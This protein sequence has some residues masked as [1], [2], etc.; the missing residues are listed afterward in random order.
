MDEETIGTNAGKVWKILQSENNVTRYQLVNAT[1]LEPSDI[2][3]AIG[4][5]AK[6]NK[7]QR[8]GEFFSL[9]K[10]NMD[11]TIGLNAQILFKVLKN[12]PYDVSTLHELTDLTPIE[13]HQAIGWLS[14]EGNVNLTSEPIVHEIVDETEKT[15]EYLRNEV[16]MLTDDLRNR[17]EI[18]CQLSRQLTDR[19]MQFIEQT[20]VIDQ[21][22]DE[23]EKKTAMVS[24]RDLDLKDKNSQLVMLQDEFNSL[25]E[26]LISRNQ[27]ITDL[28]KQLTNAQMQSIMQTDAFEKLQ[29][30]FVNG[31]MQ[32]TPVA[33]TQIQKRLNN[34]ESVQQVLKTESEMKSVNMDSRLYNSKSPVL[35]I[36]EN[37]QVDQTVVHPKSIDEIHHK[38]DQVLIEK[39]QKLKNH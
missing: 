6:E 39:M 17:D 15:L 10:T 30:S 8:D 13:I 11:K 25:H 27:I 38:L 35:D 14:R 2:D 36:Q 1:A 12:V 9:G 7:I 31:K 23:L 19:Q 18:I 21:I 5:L 16:E 33:Q 22:H 37:Q 26:D 29:K 32:M 3:A 28:S 34:I 20:H 24:V 4:W